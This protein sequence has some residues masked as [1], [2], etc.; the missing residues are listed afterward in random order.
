MKRKMLGVIIG[1]MLTIAGFAQ[2]PFEVQATNQFKGVFVSSDFK[3]R[4]YEEN[5]EVVGNLFWTDGNKIYPL[6]AKLQD[7]VL[8]GHFANNAKQFPFSLT[9]QDDGFYFKAGSKT[10]TMNKISEIDFED[11]WE[12]GNVKVI[13]EKA[14]GNQYQGFIFFNG[15][16]YIFA[17][18]ANDISITGKFSKG[19]QSFPVTLMQDFNENSIK[20]TTGAYSKMLSGKKYLLKQQ[21]KMEAMKE[22]INKNSIGM[23]FVFVEP[24]SFQMGS[25][26]GDS[27]EKPVHRVL[28]TKPF[29]MGKYEVTQSEYESIMG[30]NPSN[31]S[32][33]NNPVEEVSWHDAIAFCKTLTERE[34]NAGRLSAG[35]KYRLPTEA[36]WEYC[37]KGGNKSKGYTYSGS[38]SI[39]S[40]GWYTSNSGSET[41][42]VGQKQANELGLY[43]MSGNVWEWCND[44]YG[45]YNSKS[46]SDPK[47][48]AE[49]STRVNR[50]GGWGNVDLGCCPANRTNLRPIYKGD[51]MGFRVLLVLE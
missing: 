46:V 49:T 20:F 43:D 25:N 39:N 33:S 48:Y 41:H 19:S 31:F 44:W 17:G 51:F 7:S 35:A 45:N 42:P 2:N 32:G 9:S 37:A 30:S 13:L 40:V 12:G 11:T 1:A 50:G 21:E 6:R 47:G 14:S 22:Q 3:L 4:M 10:A 18:R 36:E 23:K 26:N 5:G 15:Q 24:G 34:Q 28:L 38:D 27:D 8:V 16:K 29:A